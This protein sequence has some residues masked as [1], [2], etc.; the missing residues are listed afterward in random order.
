MRCA[1]KAASE[2]AARM[3]A[4]GEQDTQALSAGDNAPAADNKQPATPTVAGARGY[5]RAASSPACSAA[6]GSPMYHGTEIELIYS[7]ESDSPSDSKPSAKPDRTV[8]K[9]ETAAPRGSLDP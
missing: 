5:P 9:T 6:C 8:A 2:A 1:N 4:A 7:G 3:R